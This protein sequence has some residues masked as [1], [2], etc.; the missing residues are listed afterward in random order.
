MPRIHMIVTGTLVLLLAGG[1]TAEAQVD[2]TGLWQPLFHEDQPERLPGPSIGDY[3]GLPINAAARMRAESWSASL[4]TLPEHQCKPH[5]V[6][7]GYRG[8]A[9]LRIQQEVDFDTQRVRRLTLYIEWM[10]QYREVWMDGRPRP[11]PLAPHTWQGFST[12]TWEGDTL[13]VTTTHMKA[14]W[15]RRNGVPYSDL[16]TFTDRWTRHGDVLTQ[17]AMLEDPVYL[18][19]PFVRTTNWRAAPNMQIRAYP[20]EPVNEIADRGA[21]VVPHVLPGRNPNLEDY[22]RDFKLPLDAVRGGAETA[23]PRFPTTGRT[24]PLAA[25]PDT[26][27]LV[28][29]SGITTVPVQGNV[30][31]I[32]GAGGNVV[33]QSGE[34]GVLV[35]DSGTAER[36]PDLLKAIESLADGRRIKWI[37]NTHAHT[38]HTGG[39]A[40]INTAGGVRA[41]DAVP[42][43]NDGAVGAGLPINIVAHDA[44][45]ARMTR[46]TDGQAAI[47]FAGLPTST[48]VDEV[49]EIYFNGEAI[50]LLHV[51]AAHTDG[52]VLVF[53]RKSDV[54][55]AGDVFATTGYPRIDLAQGGS[56]DGEIAA[57]NQLLRL[58]VPRLN[59]EG[60]T[61]VVPGE[62]RVSDEADVVEYR[63]MVTIIRDRVADMVTR[64][65]TLDAVRSARPTRDYDGRFA[66][67]SGPGSADAFV[68]TVYRS[69][70]SAR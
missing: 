53:F 27:R 22:A 33:V 18:T 21:G 42:S 26:S 69:L 25:G 35:V 20:C 28:L 34:D 51:P 45:L 13:V 4:L 60:G 41:T 3:V 67:A 49:K 1:A 58:T 16:A 32:A 24:A 14:G 37:V 36:V 19:E 7:Y 43:F 63:D 65:M 23:L 12:G 61:Y 17:V 70:R 5:P 46:G 9:N 68:E 54:V 8:P 56:I 64:G 55:V 47:P 39:N 11:G 29:P 52:D 57:L 31:L 44:A 62:G 38:D 6:A 59:Q 50:Q 40:A 66:A 15:V 10:Q 30:F 2:L 48:F